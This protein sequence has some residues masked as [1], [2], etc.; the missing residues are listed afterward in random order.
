LDGGVLVGPV[1]LSY[2]VFETGK[3]LMWVAL[4]G[5]AATVTSDA[6]MNPFDG[7]SFVVQKQRKLTGSHQATYANP[8]F[9]PSHSHGLC[10]VRLPRRRSGRILRLLPDYHHHDRPVHCGPIL[11]IR[12][13]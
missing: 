6:L 4:A 11:S 5:A 12:I 3:R 1:S 2:A 8:Q 13:P 7:E 9:A 10:P